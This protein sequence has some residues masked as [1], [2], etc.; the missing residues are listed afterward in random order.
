MELEFDF[1]PARYASTLQAVHA[2]ETEL[3]TAVKP[4][5]ENW[6]ET[7]S[8]VDVLTEVRNFFWKKKYLLR[9][10]EN[11]SKFAPAFESKGNYNPDDHL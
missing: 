7:G 4:L 2:L 3:E 9:I 10:S 5:L 11:L 1:D 8:S 6:S